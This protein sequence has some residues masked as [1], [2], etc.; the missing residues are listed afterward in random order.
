MNQPRQVT[1][2]DFYGGEDLAGALRAAAAFVESLERPMYPSAVYASE[3]NDQ[4]WFVVVTVK[5]L[6]F[7]P[8]G[9]PR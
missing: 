5:S 9:R 6:G 1:E 8:S 2:Y 3:D 7:G 4:G